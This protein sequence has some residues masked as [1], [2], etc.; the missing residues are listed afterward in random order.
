MDWLPINIVDLIV[1]VV[2]LLSA[3]LAFSRGFVH[4]VLGVGAWVAAIFATLVV[5][6]RS[7]DRP[8]QTIGARGY[9]R[10]CRDLSWHYSL[11]HRVADDRVAVAKA[12]WGSSTARL[13]SCSGWPEVWLS[14]ACSGSAL[15]G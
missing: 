5:F 4:E 8:T 12:A 15:R 1:I 11:L 3:L 7:G 13:A 9:R 10:R 2:L 6:A 14:F